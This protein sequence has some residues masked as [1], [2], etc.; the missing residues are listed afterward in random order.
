MEMRGRGISL[1]VKKLEREAG[2]SP[3]PGVEAKNSGTI[4][5]LPYKLIRTGTTLPYSEIRDRQI[6]IRRP[7]AYIENNMFG[8]SSY[9]NI[10][11]TKGLTISFYFLVY[12]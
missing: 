8:P 1:E 11:L 5:P 6:T 12:S 9:S 4:P 7:K 3:S 2:Y 10:I